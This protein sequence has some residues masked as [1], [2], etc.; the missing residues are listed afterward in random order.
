MIKPHLIQRL[1]KGEESAFSE[2]VLSTS[3]HLMTVAKVYTNSYEDAEDVLQDAYIICFEKIT[4]FDN[5]EPKAFYS[6]LKRVTINTAISKGRKKYRQSEK[7][8]DVVENE[9]AFDAKIINELSKKELMELIFRLPTGFR[10]VFALFVIE[11]Y[12]HKEIGEMLGI[13]SSTSRSQFVRAKR[14]L[15]KEIR[16][17]YSLDAI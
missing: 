6:W 16:K 12:S 5:N 15:Q 10:Q 1:K 7:S 4:S 14:I 9:Y 2:L 11:G 13:T 17:H 8:L 3:L